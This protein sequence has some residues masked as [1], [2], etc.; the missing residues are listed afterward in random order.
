MAFNQAQTRTVRVVVVSLALVAVIVLV[1]AVVGGGVFGASTQAQDQ[2]GADAQSQGQAASGSDA[3]GGGSSSGSDDAT[4]SMDQVD[5]QYSQAT[6]TLQ[7]QYEADPDNPSALLNLA[8]GYFDWGAAARNYVQDDDD[9]AHVVDLFSQAIARYDDYLEKYGSGSGTNKSVQVDRAIAIFYTGDHDTA[10]STLE[11]FVSQTDD[12]GPAWANLGM[13]YESENRTDDAR[14]AY[15]KAIDSDADN[16]YG[17]KDY[18]QARLDALDAQASG[19]GANGA[20]ADA[21][22]TE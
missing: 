7:A 13:F 17:V 8:N 4:A 5:A 15:E 2:G 12:F 22:A 6:D 18:A 1:V 16:S 21:A 19:Q 10:I 20:D 14:S 3:S 9:D 11:Q